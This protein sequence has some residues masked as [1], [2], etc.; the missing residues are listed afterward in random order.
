METPGS[1]DVL[2][3]VHKVH[4]ISLQKYQQMFKEV[5]DVFINTF[6]I[7]YTDMF[8]L[9]V[10]SSTLT[11]LLIIPSQTERRIVFIEP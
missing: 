8:R 10:A 11:R 4:G 1:V 9:M 3:A 5:V 6:Q 7:L 2:V